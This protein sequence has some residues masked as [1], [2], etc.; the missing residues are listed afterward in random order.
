MLAWRNRIS[1]TYTT[2]NNVVCPHGCAA[3]PQ[4]VVRL[5]SNPESQTG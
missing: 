2:E 3:S 5:S 4:D 1:V